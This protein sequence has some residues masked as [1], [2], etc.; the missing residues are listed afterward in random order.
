MVPENGSESIKVIISHDVRVVRD[1]IA[2]LLDHSPGLTV[3]KGGAPDVVLAVSALASGAATD[4]IQRIKDAF[5]D[6]KVVIMGASGTEKENLEYIEAGASGYVL[7]GSSREHLIEII[8][9]IHRGEAICPPDILPRLFERI[10]SLRSQLKIAQEKDRSSLTR[11]ELEVLQLVADGMNNKEI[12][13]CLRVELQ[14][15]KNHVHNILEKLRVRNR[16]EAIAC[17]RK[18]KTAV[19]NE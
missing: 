12:A 9:T 15:V 7:P 18:V 11:R 17:T 19:G 13:T 10:A 4:H 2:S 1:G 14:T 6:A 3:V 8:Q 16:W 5:P